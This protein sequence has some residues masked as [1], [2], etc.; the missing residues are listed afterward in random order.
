MSTFNSELDRKRFE[1]YL[2]KPELL[3][4]V[5]DWELVGFCNHCGGELPP[6]HGYFT[7]RGSPIRL[8]DKGW[9]FVRD[10]Y[11]CPHCAHC[12]IG[13]DVD[14]FSYINIP[15]IKEKKSWRRWIVTERRVERGW[16]KKEVVENGFWEY[17]DC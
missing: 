2:D 10:N 14:P 1:Y 17:K 12:A 15:P 6:K 11:A 4:E 5:G 13:Y 8:I 3:V 9:S 16:F 7:G